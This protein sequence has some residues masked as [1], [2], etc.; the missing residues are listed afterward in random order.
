M[1]CNSLANHVPNNLGYM[2]SSPSPSNEI[3]LALRFGS[4]IDFSLILN[5]S[6]C[7]CCAILEL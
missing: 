1:A 4:R 7:L 5:E 3:Y 2:S 6:C